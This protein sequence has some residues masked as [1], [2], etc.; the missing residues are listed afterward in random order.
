MQSPVTPQTTRILDCAQALIARGGYNGFSYADISA[1]VGIAKATIHHHFPRKADLV[2]VL[3]RR[4][5]MAAVE[6][7]AALNAT[8]ANPLGRLRA[9]A[10]WWSSCILDGSMS[11]CVCAVLGAE[12]PSLPSE[13]ACEVRSHFKHLAEWLEGVMSAGQAGQFLQL[14]GAPAAEAQAFMATVH[15]AMLSARACGDPPLF[16]SIVEATLNQLA[17]GE[18]AHRGPNRTFD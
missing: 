6:G 3:V 5:R 16:A 10:R 14:H 9:Y 8:I 17:A 13:V 4:H 12:T 18:P 15:G 2:R 7:M 1:E 11:I